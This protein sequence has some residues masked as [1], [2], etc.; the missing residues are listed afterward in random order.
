MFKISIPKPCFTAWENMTPNADGRYCNACEKTVVDF[1]VIS[2]EAVQQYFINNYDQ[3]ICGR[4]KNIQLQR[5]VI[6]LP[7]NI[8][9]LQLPFWKKFL[10]LF[11][12]CF[13]G[14]FLS[15]DTTIAGNSFTQGNPISSYKKTTEIKNDKKGSHKKKNHRGKKNRKA[16]VYDCTMVSGNIWTEPSVPVF[17][18]DSINYKA[19]KQNENADTGTSIKNNTTSNKPPE[20]PKRKNPFSETAFILPVAFTPGNPFSKKKKA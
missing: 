11:L 13:G 8:F 9:R 7:Q 14:S 10:V 19:L 16:F 5:I 2:D 17:P 3:K 6:E 18:F 15:I 12:I 20:E 1:S 4:F